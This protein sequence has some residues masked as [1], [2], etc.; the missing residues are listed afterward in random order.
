M[1]K[2][3]Q[4]RGEPASQAQAICARGEWILGVIDQACLGSSQIDGRTLMVVYRKLGLQLGSAENAVE[5]GITEVWNL[6]VSARLKV[7]RARRTGFGSF[8]N[9][10]A[11]TRDQGRSSK[12]D[13]HLMDATRYL[14]ISGGPA[15]IPNRNLPGQRQASSRRCGTVVKEPRERRE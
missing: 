4:G 9:T 2:H 5:A 11:M 3:S 6:L 13:D 10:T 14:I 8:A 1:A 7:M 15:C 12:R